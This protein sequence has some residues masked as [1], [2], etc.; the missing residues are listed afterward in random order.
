MLIPPN[1]SGFQTGQIAELQ[2]LVP[3][4]MWADQGG[5]MLSPPNPD[6]AAIPVSSL[7][8]RVLSGLN[9]A[10]SQNILAMINRSNSLSGTVGFP[11]RSLLLEIGDSYQAG[12]DKKA[13][14]IFSQMATLMT[15]RSMQVNN[16]F[17]VGSGGKP[18]NATFVAYDPKWV[19]AS[20]ATVNI[21]LR[22]LGNGLLDI[23][24]A[25]ATW[26]YTPGASPQVPG[27][28]FDRV[29]VYYARGPAGFG[30]F[31]VSIDGGATAAQTINNVNGLSDVQ[32][33]TVNVTGTATAVTFKKNTGNAYIIAVCCRT[34]AI[35][36]IESMTAGYGGMPVAY[37]TTPIA[38][39]NYQFGPQAVLTRLWSSY[40]Y[41]KVAIINGWYNDYLVDGTA[42]GL[43]TLLSNLTL[44]VAQFRQNNTD[45]IYM[46]YLPFQIASLPKATFDLWQDAVINLMQR[47]N[48]P[49][50]DPRLYGTTY[51]NGGFANN[52]YNDGIHPGPI[53]NFM[54][55]RTFM[56][57]FDSMAS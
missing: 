55:A 23:S 31:D 30:T 47:L 28:T 9:S 54:F 46:G 7:S 41:P 45:L 21:A 10:N 42:V 25:G 37:L 43:Q 50:F 40:L 52:I 24:A 2:R 26:T 49:Y 36:T 34:D 44:L 51:E 1:S 53:G 15:N 4:I 13:N 14:N 22:G 8:S 12:V 29:D 20:G 39:A 48:V 57:A 32:V 56:N 18:N 11:G 16:N 38:T 6:K 17:S 27:G 19:A 33:T 5:T 35:G 3:Q